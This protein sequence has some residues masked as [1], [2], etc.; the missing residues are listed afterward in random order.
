VRIT[1]SLTAFRARIAA[2]RGNTEQA[3]ALFS[4]AVHPGVDDLPCSTRPPITISRRLVG[5]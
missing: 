5:R 2:I 1:G 4:D 3:V